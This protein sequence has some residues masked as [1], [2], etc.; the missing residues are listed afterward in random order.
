MG[1]PQPESSL[2]SRLFI[3]ARVREGVAPMAGEAHRGDLHQTQW[4]TVVIK[5][6]DNVASFPWADSEPRQPERMTACAACGGVDSRTLYAVH[7]H[8]YVA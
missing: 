4:R 8:T 6:A 7:G 2:A 3:I 5:V 1:K